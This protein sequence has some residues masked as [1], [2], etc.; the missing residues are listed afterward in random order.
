MAIVSAHMILSVLAALLYGGLAWCVATLSAS[1]AR[2]MLLALAALHASAIYTGFLVPPPAFGFAQAMSISAWLVLVVYLLESR[3]LPQLRARGFLAV[4]GM[5]AVLLPLFFPGR[6]LAPEQSVWMGLHIALG[7]ASYALFSCAVLHAW[8]MTR[9]EAALRQPGRDSLLTGNLPVMT[10]ERLMFGF[11]LAGWL[12]LSATLLA[13][14]LFDEWLYGAAMPFQ[15]TH[16]VV[17]AWLAWLIFVLLLVGRWRLGWR[18]RKAVHMVY[19]GG[20]FLL[21]SYIGSRFVLE[22]VLHRL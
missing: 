22:V 1:G 20:A 12:L 3:A 17:F 2:R 16:K 10:L 9:A 6:A 4:V 11:V 21:L 5:V 15:W 19:A 13:G 8:L 18:G 7:M 14:L